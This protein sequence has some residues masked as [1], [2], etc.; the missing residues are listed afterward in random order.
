M[1]ADAGHFPRA[2]AALRLAL[3]LRRGDLDLTSELIRMEM[4]KSQRE[5]RAVVPPAPLQRIATPE[6]VLVLPVLEEAVTNPGITIEVLP[7]ADEWPQV[8]R[9]SVRAVA[10]KAGPEARWVVV[11]SRTEVH[12]GRTRCPGT[13]GIT[14]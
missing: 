4:K 2:V 8:R 1:L 3:E 13:P 11:E 5:A 14:R 10:L 7:P 6:H 9:L 12:Q